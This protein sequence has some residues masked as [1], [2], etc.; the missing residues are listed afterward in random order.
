MAGSVS[1]LVAGAGLAGLAAARDLTESGAAVTVIEARPRLGGRV[2][3]SRTPFLHRQHAEAGADLIDEAQEE[4][5]TLA[6]GLHLKLAEI[7]PGG[8]TAVRAAG[9]RRPRGGRSWWTEIERRLQPEIRAYRLSEERWDGAIARALAR[10]SLAD[11]LARTR[12]PRA[13][14]DMAR[15]LRGF[16]LADPEDLSLLAVVDQFA[17]AGAPGGGKMFRVIGGNQRIAEALA[18]RL[19]APVRLRTVLRRVAQGPGGLVASVEAAGRM[20][21]VRCDYLISTLPATTLRHVVFD[22]AMPAPQRRAIRE[23]RYGAATKTLLQFSRAVWRR[24]GAAR[25]FGTNLPIG[26]VWDGNEEQHGATGILTLLAGGRAAHA[27]DRLVDDGGPGRL[28]R[29]MRWLDLRRTELLASDS[30]R[31]SDD[32]WARG[33]YAF[34]HAGCDPELRRWLARP[35]GR[36]FF[37]GEHTSQRWQGY[38]NGAV[39]SG[40]RAA[41]E[42]RA[43]ARA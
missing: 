5:R 28:L 40:L 1:V 20:S 14:R 19:H 9:S 10:E 26:A 33:G 8:F 35:F 11:W 38:M 21:Q 2:L 36:V 15:G 31:W 6:A 7:L 32:P 16:F 13:L 18:A 24:R 41:A 3:T 12:A 43:T 4:I 34:F 17:D 23:L 37:G 29:E 30:I 27:T 42:V 22:P 39:E 25:A